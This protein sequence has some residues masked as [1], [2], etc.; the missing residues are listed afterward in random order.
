[1]QARTQKSRFGREKEKEEKTKKDKEA[2]AKAKAKR[3][4]RQIR[5]AAHEM[6]GGGGNRQEGSLGPG[7]DLGG[8]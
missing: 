6:G 5:G 8:R 3:R 2:K 1:M 7:S 4:S